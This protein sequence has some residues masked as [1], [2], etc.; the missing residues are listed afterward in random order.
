MQRGPSAAARCCLGKAGKACRRVEARVAVSEST[1]TSTFD[2]SLR[3]LPCNPLS[4]LTHPPR[5]LIMSGGWN[6]LPALPLSLVFQ[7][8]AAQAHGRPAT[9]A[10]RLL[11]G[12]AAVNRHWRA[13]A[14]QEVGGGGD[15]AR[16]WRVGCQRALPQTATIHTRSAAD[17]SQ[18]GSPCPGRRWSCTWP[19]TAARSKCG[20]WS[21]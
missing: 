3:Y 11:C 8:L 20:R 21:R 17:R 18:A 16:W 12:P 1:G 6:D 9:C 13:V 14:L 7:H 19:A 5:W 2:Q 15:G 10:A 4:V